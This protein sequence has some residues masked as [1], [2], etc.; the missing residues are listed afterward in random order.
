MS[1]L[2]YDRP[3]H[4]DPACERC[5]VAPMF[6][7]HACSDHRR[8]A[9]LRANDP[10]AISESARYYSRLIADPEADRHAAELAEYRRVCARQGVRP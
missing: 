2:S 7:R 5:N 3:E 1:Y 9:A 10:G 4:A 8:A 6:G